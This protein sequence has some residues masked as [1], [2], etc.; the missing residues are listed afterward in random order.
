MNDTDTDPTF[1]GSIPEAYD[2]L[3]VPLIFEPYAADLARRVRALDA[4]SILEIAAGTGVVTRAV[5]A[6]T[7]PQSEITATDLSE[8]MLERAQLSGTS[9]PVRWLQADALD[10]PF[11]DASFDVVL[12]QFGVMFF[13][14]KARAYR[15]AL[16]VLR[17]GGTFIFN[18]WGSLQDNDFALAVSDGITSI[19]PDDPPTFLPTVPFS[20]YDETVI[21]AELNEAGFESPA[22]FEIVEAMSK[23]E[24]AAA[25]AF[26][27]CQGPPSA[28]IESKA[29][30]QLGAAI[31][32]ATATLEERFGA[33][34]I[35]GKTTALV[36]TATRP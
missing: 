11:D 17:P 21:L 34:D 28:E 25:A 22:T 31:A 35:E 20:Y 24:T 3:L 15:E 33:S 30:G 10:L 32:A 7:S 36:I 5:A 9:R 4:A 2:Q 19:F 8:G 29:P 23:A 6:A 26:A 16:R 12:C 14:D 13:P 1:S 27:L 18:V